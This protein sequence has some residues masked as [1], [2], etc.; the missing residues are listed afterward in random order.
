[1]AIE[2]LSRRQA[3]PAEL[4]LSRPDAWQ[5]FGLDIGTLQ[6]DR[7][8]GLVLTDDH[9]Q[10]RAYLARQTSSQRLLLAYGNE[11]EG[12]LDGRGQTPAI[13]I[14]AYTEGT[15]RVSADGAATNATGPPQSDRLPLL[16]RDGAF[17]LLMAMPTLARHRDEL[18]GAEEHAPHD[19]Q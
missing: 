11:D 13:S 6:E 12:L 8:P 15:S 10:T 16:T 5:L 4:V 2:I 18:D 7:I 1:M 19:G 17:E 9:E 14:S 3:I